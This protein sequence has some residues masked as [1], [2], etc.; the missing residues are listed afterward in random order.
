MAQ[1]LQIVLKILPAGEHNSFRS[2]AS[3]GG[4]DSMGACKVAGDAHTV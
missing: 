3:P 1:K 4:L 2:L